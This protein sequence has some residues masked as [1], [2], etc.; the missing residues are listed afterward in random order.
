MGY[1]V[2]LLR[3]RAGHSGFRSESAIDSYRTARHAV[4]SMIR[5]IDS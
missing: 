5:A 4:M 3:H 2:V 1:L